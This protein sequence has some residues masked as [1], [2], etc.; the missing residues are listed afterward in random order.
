MKRTTVETRT[1]TALRVASMRP[2]SVGNVDLHARE[3]STSCRRCGG[4][5]NTSARPSAFS[6][7]D[8]AA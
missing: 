5:F 7:W 2:G 1:A 4:T 8:S 6:A 3:R